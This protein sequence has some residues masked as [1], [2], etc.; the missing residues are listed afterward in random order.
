MERAKGGASII[1]MAYNPQCYYD[2]CECTKCGGLSG[3][4]LVHHLEHQ[5]N[6]RVSFNGRFQR[7]YDNRELEHMWCTLW[8][9]LSS[10]PEPFTGCNNWEFYYVRDLIQHVNGCFGMIY[11]RFCGRRLKVWK[12]VKECTIQRFSFEKLL[13]I[14]F[15]GKKCF[16]AAKAFEARL[17]KQEEEDKLKLCQGKKLLK[18]IRRLCR[19]PGELREACRLRDKELKPDQSLPA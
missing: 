16:G 6:K 7:F 18:Q 8:P 13:S 19:N 11:C 10:R 15:C 1:R 9:Q 4:Q 17:V 5:W 2:G 12:L 3:A 14:G